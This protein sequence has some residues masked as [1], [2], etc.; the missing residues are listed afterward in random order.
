MMRDEVARLQPAAAEA[1]G[2]RDEIVGAERG[3]ELGERAERE[4]EPPPRAADLRL[5]LTAMLIGHG[6]PSLDRPHQWRRI[7]L[8]RLNIA[9]R[10]L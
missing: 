8:D 7:D 4:H 3:L 6:L 5:D 2:E 1:L 10:S 9:L